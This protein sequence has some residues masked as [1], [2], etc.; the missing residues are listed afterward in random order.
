MQ[1]HSYSN[2]FKWFYDWNYSLVLKSCALRHL[3]VRISLY[4]QY[5]PFCAARSRD[6]WRMEHPPPWFLKTP[7]IRAF[8]TT[9]FKSTTFLNSEHIPVQCTYC[10]YC[11]YYIVLLW[12]LQGMPGQVFGVQDKCYCSSTVVWQAFW[13]VQCFFWNSVSVLKQRVRFQ[14]AVCAAPCL[15]KI[16]HARVYTVNLR[17]NLVRV[18]NYIKYII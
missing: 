6:P 8:H 13:F 4:I 16:G 9:R 3:N 1:L 7:R 11:L 2:C 5:R 18:Y 15:I 12:W 17:N 10:A 14:H